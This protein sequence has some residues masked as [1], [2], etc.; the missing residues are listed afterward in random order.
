MNVCWT[1][2]WLGMIG[3]RGF[4]CEWGLSRLTDHL[5]VTSLMAGCWLLVA[6]NQAH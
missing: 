4:M 2:I 3:C 1:W 6:V 5:G